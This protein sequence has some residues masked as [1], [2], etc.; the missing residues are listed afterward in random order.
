[1]GEK[2]TKREGGRETH[3][4]RERHIQK[5]RENEGGRGREREVGSNWSNV[6]VKQHVKGDLYTPKKEVQTQ[7]K[8]AYIHQD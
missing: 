3:R 2:E 6:P 5:I 7:K 8:E 1:V 4:K